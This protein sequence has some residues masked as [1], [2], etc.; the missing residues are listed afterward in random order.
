LR[1]LRENVA[2]LERPAPTGLGAAGIQPV[3]A[4]GRAPPFRTAGLVLIDAP[5]TGTG[6]L[7]RHPDARWRILPADLAALAEVQAG[8]LDAAASLVE[9]DGL[10]VYATCS[11]EP[12]ENEVQVESFLNTHPE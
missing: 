11:L 7:R 4:D 10:L 8:L 3:V 6:T 5:C 12:E 9:P 1:R 2:R